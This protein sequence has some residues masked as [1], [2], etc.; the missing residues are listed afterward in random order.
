MRFHIHAVV[1]G[2]A[3]CCAVPLYAQDLQ[4]DLVNQS[5]VDL[6]ELY[7]S[8]HNVDAWGEDVLGTDVLASGDNV[9]VTVSNDQDTCDYDLRFVAKDGSAIERDHVDLCTISVFT[10]TD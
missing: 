2:I 9:S 5:S 7:V 4:F 3:S 10:L 1:V 8:A 6:H